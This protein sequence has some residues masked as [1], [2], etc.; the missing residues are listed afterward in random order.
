MY[1]LASRNGPSVTVTAPGRPRTTALCEGSASAWVPT[2]SP[3]AVIVSMNPAWPPA[4]SFRS[5]SE[6]D[7]HTSG[8]IWMISRYFMA[9]P[10]VR[11]VRREQV[12][13]GH[14]SLDILPM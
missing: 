13:A 5:A 12:G 3:V 7:S 4:I 8:F 11:W 6:S 1:S 10:V 9:P 14:R 2:I